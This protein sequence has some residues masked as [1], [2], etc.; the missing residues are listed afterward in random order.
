VNLTEKDADGYVVFSIEAD[1]FLRHMVRNVV[2]T[3]VDVALGKISPEGFKDILMSKDR[4]N[5][6]VTA[7]AQGL[8]LKEVKY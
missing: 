1:G 7:P 6:G 2:G 5:A 4:K 3:L 8:V